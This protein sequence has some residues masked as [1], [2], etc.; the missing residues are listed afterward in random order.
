MKHIEDHLGDF[1]SGLIV[2]NE[3]H[4][5]WWTAQVGGLACLQNKVKG[6]FWN[7][8]DYGQEINDCAAGYFRIQQ[9]K[10]YLDEC[11]Q[12]LREYFTAN[13][14]V[15]LDGEKMTITLDEDRLDELEEGWWPVNIWLADHS[16]QD[17]SFRGIIYTG[18]CD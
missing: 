14:Q 1:E 15:E 17:E 12:M 11:C 6:Y 9:H 5:V 2:E 8:K 7:I 18:N 3:E 4:G 16:K 13:P 10:P